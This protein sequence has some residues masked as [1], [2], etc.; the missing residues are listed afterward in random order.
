[1]PGVRRSSGT[2][3]TFQSPDARALSGGGPGR[4]P[5]IEG[6]PQHQVALGAQREGARGEGVVHPHQVVE[7]CGCEECV[8]AIDGRHAN[9]I[10]CGA[11]LPGRASHVGV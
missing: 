5:L 11:S 1:M 7:E 10:G 6:A 9:T 4:I 2:G 3:G 8:G